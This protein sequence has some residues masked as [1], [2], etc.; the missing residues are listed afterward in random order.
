VSAQ[1]SHEDRILW[2]LQAA[3]PSWVPAPSLSAI[4]LQYGARIH[5]LRK[6]GWQIAN[7][8]EVREGVKHG[9]FSLPTPGS[10]PNPRKRE[11]QGARGVKNKTTEAR[12]QI[13][14]AL[15]SAGSGL[16]FRDLPTVYSDPEEV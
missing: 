9:Y 13:D 8:V 4:S 10:F 7:K 6:K 5:A 16:L 12:E 2:Q 11:D 3:F 14:P 15:P 1:R